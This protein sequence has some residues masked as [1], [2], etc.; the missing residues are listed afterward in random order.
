MKHQIESRLIDLALSIDNLCKSLAKNF[1]SYHLSTQI[2]RSSTSAALNYGEAQSA[3]S[4]KD[5]IHKSSLVLKELRETRVCL[6]L[7]NNSVQASRKESF[8]NCQ[9]E[10]DQLIAIFYKTIQSSR[11]NMKKQPK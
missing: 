8:K 4:K 5:F 6:K 7:L 3:E 10:C 1:R 2:I 9:N 11:K